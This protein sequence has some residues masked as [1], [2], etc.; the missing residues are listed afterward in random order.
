MFKKTSIAILLLFALNANAQ[1][2]TARATTSDPSLVSGSYYP[3]FQ[4]TSGN[5]RVNIKSGTVTTAP[6]PLTQTNSSGTIATGGTFQTIAI[7][8]TTR[9]SFEFHNVCTV[10]GNC[11]ATT[12]N[13]YLFVAAAGV[14]TT[15]NSIIVPP[16][17][18]YLRSQGAVPSNAIQATCAGT[19]DK[20]YLSVQ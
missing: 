18:A 2:T 19:G 16:G 15:A 3:L 14:P 5:L 10:A 12:D 1:N 9:A 20:F 17:S 13:C 8:N 6:D 7:A 4:D 11:N